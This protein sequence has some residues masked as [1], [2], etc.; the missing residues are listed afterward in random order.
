[1]GTPTLFG[2][3]PMTRSISLGGIIRQTNFHSI[4]ETKK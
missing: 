3:S 2:T 4:I 1:M